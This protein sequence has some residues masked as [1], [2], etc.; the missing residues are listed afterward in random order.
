MEIVSDTTTVFQTWARSWVFD[1]HFRG[2]DDMC[3]NKTKTT[4]S[5]L[6]VFIKNHLGINGF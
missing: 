4:L 1:K 6:F 3:C 5:S 2:H